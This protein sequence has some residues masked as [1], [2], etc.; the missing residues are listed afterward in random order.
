MTFEHEANLKLTYLNLQ[1]HL[2]CFRKI[3]VQKKIHKNSFK[4]ELPS[5]IFFMYK[6]SQIFS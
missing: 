6:L 4:V 2:R 5:D 1:W 3:K